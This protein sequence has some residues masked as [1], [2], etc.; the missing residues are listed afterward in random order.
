M[1]TGAGVGFGVGSGAGVATLAGSGLGGSGFVST[2]LGGSGLTGSG[3]GGFG[4]SGFLGS[5]LGGGGGSS[6]LGGINSI[7]TGGISIS[8]CVCCSTPDTTSR[9]ISTCNPI[10]VAMEMLECREIIV[11]AAKFF[12]GLMLCA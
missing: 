1:G 5:G 4:S 9:T 6:F 10:E 12:V 7:C 2:T 11:N 8:L 3:L